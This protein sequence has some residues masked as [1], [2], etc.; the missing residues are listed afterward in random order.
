MTFADIIGNVAGDLEDAG[1]THFTQDDLFDSAKDC[2]EILALTTQCIEKQFTLNTL[3]ETPYYDVSSLVPDY[4]RPIAI[5]NVISQ[6]WLDPVAFSTIKDYSYRWESMR[7]NPRVWCPMATRDIILHPTPPDADMQFIVYYKAYLLH[8]NVSLSDTPQ[9]PF[10]EL[11]AFE[12]YIKSDLYDIDLEFTKSS[13]WWDKFE[14]KIPAIKKKVFRRSWPDRILALG[15][16]IFT[17]V[18]G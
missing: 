3:A 6:R 13:E 14:R 15:P 1:M 17:H 8:D 11:N 10:E 5:F 2:Y 9:I 7:A 12:Y 16:T 18:P 4:Y